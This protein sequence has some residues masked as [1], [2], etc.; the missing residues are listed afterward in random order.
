[1]LS[2]YRVLDLSDERGLLAGQILADLGADVILV[3]PPGGSPARGIAPF[4]GDQPGVDRS[5]FWWAYARNRRGV[6]CD[7]D[8]PAGQELIRRLAATADFVIESDTPGAMAARGLGYDDLRAINDQLIYVSISAF[9][10]DG[11]KATYEAT[12]LILMAAG[13]PLI[14]AGDAGQEP[15]RVSVP[16][17]WHHAA[18]EAASA[19]LVAL[20]ARRAIGRGQQVDISAQQSVAAATMSTIVSH[21]IGAVETQRV[22]G[23][24]VVG[25]FRG[26][27]IWRAA[28]GHISLTFLFGSGIG[29]F[30]QRLMNWIYECGECEQTDRDLDWIGLGALFLSGE[31]ALSEWDRLLGV[32]GK[33]I[34]RRS[35]AELFDE[36]RSRGLLIVPVTTVDEVAESEQFEVREFWQTHQ[37]PGWEQPVRF[38][39]PFVRMTGG[40][41]ISYRRRAPTLGEH[42]AEVYGELEINAERLAALAAEGVI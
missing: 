40:S 7:I 29:P 21:G 37:M 32:V 18:G 5:L 22:A 31:L 33:F 39:G 20:H 13:G 34:E 11:P 28:D 2:P 12:D 3:E 6:T 23:G 35:R 42:N 4:A 9:G 8:T 15:V 24:M 17:A 25:P 14:L 16:Q 30:S 38:P 10:Q 26:K 41:P 1:M 19:A 36:A 27:L